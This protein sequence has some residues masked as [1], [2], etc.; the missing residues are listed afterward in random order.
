MRA[1]EPEALGAHPRQA[2]SASMRA[3]SWRS[4]GLARLKALWVCRAGGPDA[5]PRLRCGAS[6]PL[7]SS[8]VHPVETPIQVPLQLLIENC[9][10]GDGGWG[11]LSARWR[12]HRA[13]VSRERATVTRQVSNYVD[14]FS[15]RHIL[16]FSLGCARARLLLFCLMGY[17]KLK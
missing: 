10:S 16:V 17:N 1:P 8:T 5:T 2:P 13:C 4:Q 12:R 15:L 6:D 14:K 3:S 7:L 9:L 11:G